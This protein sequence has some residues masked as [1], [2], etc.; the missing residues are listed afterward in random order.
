MIAG[1]DDKMRMQLEKLIY[2]K[3][4]AVFQNEEYSRVQQPEEGALEEQQDAVAT[5]E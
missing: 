2:T 3:I 4:A 5:H 1:L